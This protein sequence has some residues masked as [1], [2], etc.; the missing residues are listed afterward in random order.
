MAL[1]KQNRLKKK[2]DFDEVFKKGKAANGAFLFIKFRKSSSAASRFGFVV[3]TK[4]AKKAVLRN[5]IRRVLSTAVRANL[6]PLHTAYD[7]AVIVGR[8]ATDNVPLLG[9][10]ILTVLR[11]SNII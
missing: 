1:P 2:K 11:R 6:S 3:S 7:V 4:V 5:K 10:D 8:N 9:Q